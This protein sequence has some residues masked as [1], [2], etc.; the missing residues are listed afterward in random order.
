MDTR[1]VDDYL[2]RL[3]RRERFLSNRV[4]DKS[5]DKSHYDRAEL[6]ALQWIIRYAEDTM[7]EAAE[8]QN[9]WFNELGEDNGS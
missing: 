4:D 6:I 1:R 3:K 9:K 2:K 7:L 5:V 8:H